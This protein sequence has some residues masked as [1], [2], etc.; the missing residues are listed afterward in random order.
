M[1]FSN[2]TQRRRFVRYGSGIVLFGVLVAA[3]LARMA[4]VS[5]YAVAAE[6]ICRELLDG[7]T[8]G[9]QALI[10][11]AWWPPLPILLRLPVA[12][13]I[14]P[15][16]GSI[17]SIVVGAL[18]GVATLLLLER[19]LFVWHAGWIRFGIVAAAGAH[20]AFLEAC[21]NGSTLTSVTFVA[22]LAIFSLAEWTRSRKLRFLSTFAIAAGLLPTFTFELSPWLCVVFLACVIDTLLTRATAVKKRATLLLTF[23][24]VLYVVGLWILVNWL[25]MGDALYFVRSVQRLDLWQGAETIEW[26]P[27]TALLWCTAPPLLLLLLSLIRRNRPGIVLGFITMTPVALVIAQLYCQVGWMTA[28]VAVLAMPSACAAAGFLPET[29][30][31]VRSTR[32]TFLAIACLAAAAYTVNAHRDPNPLPVERLAPNNRLHLA[33]IEQHIEERTQYP[34]VFVCGYAGFGLLAGRDIHPM[35]IHNLDLSVSKEKVDYHGHTLYIL[36]HAPTG[37]SAMDSIHWKQKDMFTLG[38]R[39]L[40]Y[41]GDWDTWRLFEII[42][43]DGR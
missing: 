20:P 41:D 25:I 30:G 34:K 10:S 35:F 8:V 3:A 37:R 1:G 29:L 11:S 28:P 26:V 36:L 42:Q 13:L 24:P 7:S 38:S 12:A 22:L 40:L 9:R 16:S 19:M 17:S 14:G 21:L 33:Q 18:F 23:L 39:S 27:P 4:S 43:V 2:V 32:S 5:P 6:E 15:A 31:A